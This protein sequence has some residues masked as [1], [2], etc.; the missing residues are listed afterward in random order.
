MTDTQPIIK[1]PPRNRTLFS[2]NDKGGIP[3]SPGVFKFIKDSPSLR[4]S[5]EHW[6][7]QFTQQD[8]RWGMGLYKNDPLELS[9]QVSFPVDVCHPQALHKSQPVIYHF[10]KDRREMKKK[11][12]AKVVGNRKLADSCHCHAFLKK[13]CQP[14][15]RKSQKNRIR[16][17]RGWREFWKRLSK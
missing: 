9:L 1:A 6:K 8:E 13:K 4:N 3:V 2:G 7:D 17:W 12:S 16:Q 5:F 10:S 11:M 14:K 15:I